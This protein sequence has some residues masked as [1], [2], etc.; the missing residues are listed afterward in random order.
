MLLERETG[1]SIDGIVK[2]IPTGEPIA[3]LDC[4]AG[5]AEATTDAAGQFRLV[6]VAPAV[7]EIRC[8][9]FDN[10]IAFAQGVLSASREDHL[11]IEVWGVERATGFE[12]VMNG[13]SRLG[14]KL[15]VKNKQLVF[16]KVEASGTC[17][18]RGILSGD[19]LVK[20]AGVAVPGIERLAQFYLQSLPKGESVEIEI[21]RGD[22]QRTFDFGL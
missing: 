17:A 6:R 20:V 2:Q 21:R 22:A 19:V 4:T 7:T 9:R 14:A 13:S 1:S 10:P 5:M 12:T 18:E 8:M 16:T 3:N 15:V 11:T